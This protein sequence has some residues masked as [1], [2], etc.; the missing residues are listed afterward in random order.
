MEKQSISERVAALRADRKWSLS[1]V[2]RRSGLTKGHVH[3]LER[4]LRFPKLATRA[5]LAKAFDLSLPELM[6]GVELP[7][8][9]LSGAP[10]PEEISQYPDLAEFVGLMLR[11][12]R[13]NPR[14]ARLVMRVART[15]IE[16]GRDL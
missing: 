16:E 2:A 12:R 9:E 7:P 6:Q 11:T 5:S 15:I 14:V 8:A 4:G 13:E 10:Q 1:E 3:A